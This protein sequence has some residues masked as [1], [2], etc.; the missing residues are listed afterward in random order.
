[1]SF[2]L[3][4]TAGFLLWV[5]AGQIEFGHVLNVV[6]GLTAIAAAAWIYGRW[7]TIAKPGRTRTISGVVA[8]AFAVVGL[9]GTKPPRKDLT[10]VD[11]SPTKVEE[12]LAAG[13]PVYVDFTANWCFTC[14]INKKNAY[15]EAV[16]KI[17]RE[18]DVLLLKADKTN[19]SP[20][21]DKAIL[22]LG[23]GAVPVN[24]LYVPG[25]DEPHITRELLTGA[26]LEEFL[27]TRLGDGSPS[28]GGKRSATTP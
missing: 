12:A 15:T 2:L 10:W 25:D 20:E 14:Q 8:L 13:Q 21:I 16:R 27:G 18:R 22:E 17:I 9:L 28:G 11:W 24:V 19:P 1:M 4:A 6:V 5:Y 23:R 26:Y 7:C 3:F